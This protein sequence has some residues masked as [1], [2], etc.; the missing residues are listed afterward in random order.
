VLYTVVAISLWSLPN[1]P[2]QPQN[3]ITQS[4]RYNALTIKPHFRDFMYW[5]GLW[6]IWNMFSYDPDAT[7]NIWYNRYVSL[8]LEYP[9]GSHDKFD[10][11]TP[12]KMGEVERAINLRYQKYVEVAHPKVHGFLMEPFVS[13][14]ARRNA[15]TSSVAPAVIRVYEQWERIGAPGTANYQYPLQL[16]YEKKNPLGN[17]FAELGSHLMTP[18]EPQ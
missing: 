16:I 5:S 7:Q 12:F 10:Y 18:L 2:A 3:L 13:F 17:H 15:R 1:G 4:L 6:Q 11:P 14:F 8:D 9:D